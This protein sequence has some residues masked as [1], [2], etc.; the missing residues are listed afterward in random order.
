MSY[1]LLEPFQR[2]AVF[3]ARAVISPVEAQVQRSRRPE[4][5]QQT[6]GA[7]FGRV[8]SPAA[9]PLHPSVVGLI[10]EL[11]ELEQFNVIGIALSEAA[12]DRGVMVVAHTRPTSIDPMLERVVDERDEPQAAAIPIVKRDV[13]D[14]GKDLLDMRSH[15]TLRMTGPRIAPRRTLLPFQITYNPPLKLSLGHHRHIPNATRRGTFSHM[16]PSH[17]R[18]GPAAKVQL[19]ARSASIGVFI[20]VPAD[21]SGC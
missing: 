16:S 5:V 2:L 10:V 1:E 12:R 8:P 21:R 17:T 13:V 11:D 15:R 4:A 18:S 7:S 6:L 3:R 14:V 9:M 20:F 19:F